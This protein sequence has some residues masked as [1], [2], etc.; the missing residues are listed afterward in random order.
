[1][2]KV[3][4]IEYKNGKGR[5]EVEVDLS[6]LSM[7]DSEIKIQESVNELGNAVTEKRLHE[8][9]VDGQ[10]LMLG[11]EKYT[12]KGLY[13]CSYETPY[14]QVNI[15]R[16]L[17]QTSKGG[18]TYCP[19]NDNARIIKKTCTPKLAKIVSNKYGRDT[20][21]EVSLDMKDNHSR[22][23]AKSFIQ[24][25]SDFVGAIADAKEEHWDYKLPEIEEP[26]H[27]IAVSMDGANV[28]IVGSGYREAMTGAITLYAK[29]G[30]RLHSMYLALDPEYG[31]SRFFNRMELAIT[32]I[33]KMYPDV[34]YIGVSD[35]AHDL[36]EFLKKHTNQ[37]VLDFYH[38]TEYLADASKAI[39]PK[40]E[41]K[42]KAWLETACSSLKNISGYVPSV[43]SEMNEA[44]DKK[45]TKTHKEKLNAAITYFSNNKERMTY[46]ENKAKNLPIGSGV[47]E[48]ACKT[49][50]KSRLCRSGMRWKNKGVKVALSLRAMIKTPGKW[51]C[52]WSRLSLTG[53]PCIV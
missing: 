25:I 36:W 40:S 9:D 10:P 31:K 20:A 34:F 19:L 39:F 50:V 35:G 16:H 23:L 43:L 30:S 45:L 46:P 32:D 22:P 27:T 28:A 44:I 8:F 21:E 1:M 52:F 29:D 14:G 51:D 26:V 5:F 7:L 4:C 42:R 15:E 3:K 17:Y 13:S 33:K 38:A 6:G 47:I 41:K 24:N 48:A 18:E 49:I 12:S 2:M 53:V 37:Q 11:N